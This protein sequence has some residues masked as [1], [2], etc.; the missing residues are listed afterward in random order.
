MYT[1]WQ[2]MPLADWVSTSVGD[3]ESP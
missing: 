3:A 1:V 2:V